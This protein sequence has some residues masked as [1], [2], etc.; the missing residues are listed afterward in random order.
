VL[1]LEAQQRISQ[2]GGSF[3]E[4]VDALERAVESQM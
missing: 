1:P 3:R 4:I 2:L